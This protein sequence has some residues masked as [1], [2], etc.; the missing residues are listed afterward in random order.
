MTVRFGDCLLARDQRQLLRDGQPTALTPKGYQLLELLL[1]KRPAAVSKAEIH[2]RLWP[3]TFVS[4]VNLPALINEI[5]AAIG[6]DA[7]EPRYVRTVR[8]FG[9]AFS[10]DAVEEGESRPR[11]GLS[12]HCLFWE[13]RELRLREGRN[14]VGRGAEADV[15]VDAASV[16]RRHA[17]LVVT[18]PRVEVED[19]DS[20]N[21]TLVGEARVE[22]RRALEDG[23]E[24]RLGSVRLVYRRMHDSRPTATI[25]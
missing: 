17:C 18:G 1:E 20:K 8:G 25:G 11:G 13:E 9:Y 3:D 24:V 5:R 12:G 7:R 4:E 22:G 14:V 15:R 16:S 10:G 19:L 21:G 6:D 2:D 23:D